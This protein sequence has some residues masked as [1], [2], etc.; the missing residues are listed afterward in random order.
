MAK[1]LLLV[2]LKDWA[3]I[4]SKLGGK[5]TLEELNHDLEYAESM[6]DY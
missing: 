4:L 6:R 5:I 1:L 2:R 3:I